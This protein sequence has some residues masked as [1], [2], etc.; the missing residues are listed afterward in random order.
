MLVAVLVN[1]EC[2]DVQNAGDGCQTTQRDVE[3][4]SDV[5]S[6]ASSSAVAAELIAHRQRTAGRGSLNTPASA[7]VGAVARPFVCRSCLAS[8]VDR[9]T[10]VRHARVHSGEQPYRC[11]HCPRAFSQ[12][13]NRSRHV[14]A[15]HPQTR[16]VT[17]N[18]R[19][20]TPSVAAAVAIGN[21]QAA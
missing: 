10:L 17:S 20:H 13:G 14:R 2:V 9:A 16:V 18:R 12:S 5:R 21:A 3:N 1:G 19:K 15:K 4:A 7:R 11:A 8:F 6:D